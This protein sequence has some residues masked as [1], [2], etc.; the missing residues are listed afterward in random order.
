MKLGLPFIRR[1]LGKRS[2]MG[3]VICGNVT[4][5]WAGA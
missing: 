4:V 1:V 2:L 3:G 5:D